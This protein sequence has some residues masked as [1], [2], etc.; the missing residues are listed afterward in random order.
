MF[1][2]PLAMNV[3]PAPNLRI[4]FP[5]PGFFLV[6]ARFTVTLDGHP[7]YDGSF[8]Q[9]FDGMF[10]VAP[11]YHEI[12]TRIDMGGIARSRSYPIVISPGRGYSL[13][14]EYSRFWGNFA[15]KPKLIEHG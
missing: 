3:G 9:G 13:L 6:D 10:P 15:S 2:S 5:P 14:L 7:V 12:A 8:K 1:Q 4:T 11:G